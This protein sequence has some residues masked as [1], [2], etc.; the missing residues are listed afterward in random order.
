MSSIENFSPG[1]E[2][3]LRV[4]RADSP[5]TRWIMFVDQIQ[6]L[7]MLKKLFVLQADFVNQFRIHDDALL[8]GDGP[9][10]CV[11]LGIVHGNLDFKMP[12]IRPSHLFADF[13]GFGQHT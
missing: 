7:H 13:G 4:A 11:R 12:E 9:W 10:L 5:A 6:S 3:S 1:T 8:Q 2:V